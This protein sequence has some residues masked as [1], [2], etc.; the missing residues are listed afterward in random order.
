MTT[1]SPR[2]HAPRLATRPRSPAHP[3]CGRVPAALLAFALAVATLGACGPT[4]QVSDRN[5]LCRD[6]ESVQT[7]AEGALVPFRVRSR[8]V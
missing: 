2:H 8:L 4:L 1:M 7:Y 3:T 6:L 5:D